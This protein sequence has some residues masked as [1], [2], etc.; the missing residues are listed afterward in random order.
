MVDGFKTFLESLSN[1]QKYD[2]LRLPLQVSALLSPIFLLLAVHIHKSEYYCQRYRVMLVCSLFHWISSIISKW[3]WFGF[4]VFQ[5]PWDRTSEVRGSSRICDLE[6]YLRYCAWRDR[7]ICCCAGHRWRHSWH[8]EDSRAGRYDVVPSW[9]AGY[10][11]TLNAFN[12]PHL[13]LIPLTRT[14]FI[15]HRFPSSNH[16]SL[17]IGPWPPY[18]PP[19]PWHLH[20]AQLTPM[21]ILLLLG[22]HLRNMTTQCKLNLSLL[23]VPRRVVPHREAPTATIPCRWMNL[24]PTIPSPLNWDAQLVPSNPSILTWKCN[25]RGLLLLRVNRREDNRKFCRLLLNLRQSTK[26]PFASVL[27][28]CNSASLIWR[29][30]RSVQFRSHVLD[31]FIYDVHPAL[32]SHP[33][34]LSNSN[35]MLSLYLSFTWRIIIR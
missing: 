35:S 29:K 5:I 30:S 22:H 18:W 28:I 24:G 25:K 21:D 26:G 20:K 31:H 12:N 6:S 33:A 17:K 16:P 27:S 11:F 32:V 2:H 13:Q 23:V 10:T 8:L 7:R 19:Q 9:F 3:F 4:S 15:S 34:A 14:K 1:D